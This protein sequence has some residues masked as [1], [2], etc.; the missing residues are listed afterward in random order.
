MK[1]RNNLGNCVLSWKQQTRELNASCSQVLLKLRNSLVIWWW[2]EDEIHILPD[3]NIDISSKSP[4]RFHLVLFG[5]GPLR[6]A[7]LNVCVKS[8]FIWKVIVS[9]CSQ[10]RL[11]WRGD[12][13]CK[14][15]WPW[16]SEQGFILKG[17]FRG[18]WELLIGQWNFKLWR[19]FTKVALE[20]ALFTT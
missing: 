12:R 14:L 5:L 18:K 2:I 19:L 7:G 3:L 4:F 13:A 1:K 6:D 17:K 15:S 8:L 16:H 20:M 11:S 10:G 9:K